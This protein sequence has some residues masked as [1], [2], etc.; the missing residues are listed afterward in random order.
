MP[1]IDGPKILE[2]L[3]MNPDTSSIPVVFLTGNGKKES[4]ERVLSL[5]PKGY[6]LKTSTRQSLLD[7]IG[8]F[9]QKEH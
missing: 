1:V 6:L 4:I 8:E 2:M 7:T 9:F 3:R 5:K